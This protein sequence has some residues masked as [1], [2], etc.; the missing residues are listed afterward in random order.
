MHTG[1]DITFTQPEAA[2]LFSALVSFADDDI[3]AE[4]GVIMRKYYRYEDALS[5]KDKMDQAGLTYPD[6]IKTMEE[7]LLGVLEGADAPFK[8]RTLSVALQLAKSDGNFDQKEMSI[9][10]RCAGRMGISLGEANVFGERHLVEL[11]DDGEYI[12]KTLPSKIR[13]RPALTLA[14]A[15]IALC[16]LVAFSDDDPSEPEIGVIREYFTPKDVQSLQEKMEGAGFD[17]PGDLSLF[18]DKILDAFCDT[19]RE[20]VVKTLAIAHKV[21][22]ADGILDPRELKLIREFCEEYYL[23]FA[24]IRDYFHA[25]PD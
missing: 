22:F 24:E 18:H 21:A 3:S 19:D 17:Y 4:E 25:M 16:T 12:C 14:E 7:T 20:S 8:L 2:I 13:E 9:L 23:G 15:G 6:D 1:T 5:A 11:G 10:Q